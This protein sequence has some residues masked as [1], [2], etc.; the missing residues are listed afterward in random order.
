MDAGCNGMIPEKETSG[1]DLAGVKVLL[2]DDSRPTR[3]FIGTFLREQQ[4]EVVE[5]KDGNTALSL[6]AGDSFDLIISDI[7]MPGISGLE[8]CEKIKASPL[9]QNIPVILISSEANDERIDQGFKSGASAFIGKSEITSHLMLAINQVLA[10]RN[11]NQRRLILVVEDSPTIMDITVRS[12]SNAGYRVCCA[13]NGHEAL[14]KIRERKP[15][16]IVSDLE[17]PIMDGIALTNILRHDS[18]LADIPI[19]IAS[20]LGTHSVMRRML[21]QGVAAYLTKPYNSEQLLIAV[22]RL[23]SEQY[24]LL[25]KERQRLEQ[26]A[27][28]MLSSIE[29]LCQALEAR[30]PY[31][32]GHSED[33]VTITLEIGVMLGLS[34]ANLER[35]SIGAKL[36]DIGKI[37]VPDSILLKPGPLDEDEWRAMKRHPVIGA[38]ILKP[39]PSLADVIP[40]MLHHHE[41]YDGTGYPHGLAGENIPF[42]ARITMVADVFHALVSDRPY[43]PALPVEKAVGIIGELRGRKLCPDCVDAF[44]KTKIASP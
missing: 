12:L 1:M 16:L 19:I 15:D 33:V 44:L 27:R 41:S 36:H 22:D 2:V 39:I 37:G 38:E 11:F 10:K 23:L 21:E 14:E 6:A 26:E 17:M 28:F 31:T 42:W 7:V 20:S 4:M 25:L 32:R 13:E 8:L 34:P 5:A 29:S 35:L 43:R 18:S 24:K 40:I 3:R 30:D 9:L